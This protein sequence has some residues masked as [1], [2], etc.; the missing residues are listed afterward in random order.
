MIRIIHNN[1][2]E[3]RYQ[4]KKVKILAKWFFSS[5]FLLFLGNWIGQ[6][7]LNWYAYQLNHNAM[8]LAL[9]N[10]FRLAPIFLLSLWAGAIADRYRRSTLIKLT[11]TSSFLITG[12]LTIFVLT[13]GEL[14]MTFL[15]IYSCLRGCM[16]AIETPVRQAVLPDI[17]ERLSISKGVSYHSFVLNVCRSIGPAI[18]GFIIAIWDISIAFV[19]QTAC[20]LLALSL[21]LPLQLM[22]KKQNKAPK[23]S[24]PIAWNY[25]KL[26]VVSRRIFTTSLLIMAMGYSYTTMLPIL[27]NELFPKKASIF[28][29]AMTFSAIG[30]ILATLIIPYI[31][32][33]V[34]TDKFYFLS[35]VLFGLALMLLYP[36]GTTG[37]FIAIFC[38]GLFGQFARTT[39]RI[40]FQ[41]DVEEENRGKILSIVMMDRGMIPLGAVVLSYFTERIGITTTFLVMGVATT[42]IAIL[43]Y[44]MNLKINGGKTIHDNH[45]SSK[46]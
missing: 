9:I 32:K 4:L 18:S 23:F 36:F 28:G 16:S 7:A 8:D 34:S 35:S 29:T 6:I 24:L 2:N 12:T 39:N 33:T 30:G 3:N 25:F 21:S 15:Y 19:I 26:N 41:N 5:T 27:T 46:C 38:V 17:S 1:G 14:P 13:M 37:L 44:A 20:Y 45:S 22:V 40:Y 42:L 31:L 43:G 11:V 10:F